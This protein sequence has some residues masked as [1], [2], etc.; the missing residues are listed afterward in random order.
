MNEEGY[1][2][3]FSDKLFRFMGFGALNYYLKMFGFFMIIVAPILL[4]LV[5][6][7]FPTPPEGKFASGEIK[8]KPI[9][10]S[11]EGNEGESQQ[12][13]EGSYKAQSKEKDS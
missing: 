9:I 13:R 4:V 3:K 1:L 5:S 10:R 8:G 6:V 7:L 12:I 2:A 11:Y